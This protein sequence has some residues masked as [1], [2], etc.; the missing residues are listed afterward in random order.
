MYD[1]LKADAFINE[2]KISQ[3]D[4]RERSFFFNSKTGE[5]SNPFIYDQPEEVRG[6]ILTK[7]R[8]SVKSGADSE[9][10][11]HPEARAFLSIDNGYTGNYSG[12]FISMI[13]DYAWNGIEKEIIGAQR[14]VQIFDIKKFFDDY[15]E[16]FGERLSDG[17]LLPKHD[18]I[19]TFM[20]DFH[21]LQTSYY[22]EFSNEMGNILSIID[23]IDNTDLKMTSIKEIGELKYAFTELL[24]SY[25][26]H[27]ISQDFWKFV[28]DD[29]NELHQS[30]MINNPK[31]AATARRKRP[32]RPLLPPQKI[33][34]IKMRKMIYIQ[35]KIKLLKKK[36]LKIQ[37]L[38][39]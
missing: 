30:M 36:Y 26:D 11:S 31:A 1:M 34:V 20:S 3:S 12:D 25:D 14:D 10:H 19:Q 27:T 4:I 29:S 38:P 17:Q 6:E 37:N 13:S 5:Y 28:K 39:K 7:L 15:G 32:P 21:T 8:Q 35:K 2:H 24:G 33:K 22:S 16:K 23:Q 18:K 9:Y